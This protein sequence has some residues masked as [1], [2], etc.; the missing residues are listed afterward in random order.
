MGFFEIAFGAQKTFPFVFL[1]LYNHV[2][3]LTFRA[4]FCNGLVPG[5]EGAVGIFTAPVKGASLFGTPCRNV[6]FFTVR[7]RAGN[8]QADRF[9]EF[10]IRVSGAGHEF[11]ETPDFDDQG[12]VAFITIA[13]CFHRIGIPQ[14]LH[15]I[16]CQHC[17]NQRIDTSLRKRHFRCN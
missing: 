3:T 13:F 2:R 14:E 6:S 10:A 17:N 5:S 8:T 9:G 1:P 12:R 15:Q 16:R 11:A 4:G 7:F